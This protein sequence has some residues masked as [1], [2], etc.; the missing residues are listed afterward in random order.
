MFDG[1][2]QVPVEYGENA[3]RCQRMLRH[4]PQQ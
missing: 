1:N 3:L 4:I 2:P